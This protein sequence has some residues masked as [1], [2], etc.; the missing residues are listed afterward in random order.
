MAAQRQMY[1][2][3]PTRRDDGRQNDRIYTLA[4]NDFLAG[5]GDGYAMF[6]DAE[7]RIDTRDASLMAA[8]AM[9]YVAASGTVA[10]A[11]EGRIV[12]LD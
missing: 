1:A 4:T 3:L 10:L 7:R 6:E 9:E 11:V 2:F 12:R 8:H 5:G